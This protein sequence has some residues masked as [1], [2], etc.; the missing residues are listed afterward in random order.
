MRIAD[1]AA[2]IVDDITRM[3]EGVQDQASQMFEPTLRLGVT[4]LSRAG[5]TVFIASLVANLLDRGRMTGLVAA[6]EGR[7]EAAALR[8]HPDRS[9]PRFEWEAHMDALRAKDPH[10]PEG[11]RHVSRLRI[12][13]RVR[14]SGWFSGLSGPRA[15]HL[16][17]VD[18]PG[19]WLLDLPLMNQ[20]FPDWSTRAL[21]DAE[22][23]VRAPHA[24]GWRAALA[25]VDPA[26]PYDEAAAQHLAQAFA[27]Y[28]KAA[29]TAGL[30]GL[31]PGRFLM[32]GDLEGS[33]ALTFAPLPGGRAP[34]GSLAAEFDKRFEAYK[35][36]VIRPFFA[37]H[38]ARLDRQVVLVDVLG[39]LDAGPGALEDL[40][41]AL[42]RILEAFRPG[43]ASWLARMLGARRIDRILFAATKADH[44]H[45]SQHDRLTGMLSELLR[46]GATR[47]AFSGAKTASMAI[48]SLR[49]TTETETTRDGRTIGLVR[50]RLMPDG[51]EAAVH[52]GDLPENPAD[53]L[54]LARSG[55]L[56][57]P[58]GGFR[59]PPFQAPRLTARPGEGPP[60]I[61]LDRAAQ[62]LL[63]DFL[64]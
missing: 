14:P 13:F 21:G 56:E 8:P 35:S 61:R 57:W 64:Q 59:A 10:W 34:R 17:I 18:Y 16:D 41:Q 44:I 9:A 26:A 11:T 45:H 12:S 1:I 54:A 20:R 58:D 6:A 39:A 7:I 50:G 43:D 49:A 51:R 38:F 27:G 5:K 31:A 19:E 32:P 48:A 30:S 47:A 46:E 53:A 42:G 28:L 33:P 40:R 52:P 2:D 60:H 36:A 15:V 63:G 22:A 23:P 37:D 55:A 29:K 62:F 3:A 25:G 4:G 24:A